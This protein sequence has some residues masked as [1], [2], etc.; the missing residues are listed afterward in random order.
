VYTTGESFSDSSMNGMKNC[1]LIA[2]GSG[3]KKVNAVPI[4][5]I[6]PITAPPQQ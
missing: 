5:H 1:R 6:T 4:S 2:F 3:M